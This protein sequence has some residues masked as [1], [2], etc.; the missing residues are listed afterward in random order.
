LSI[1]EDFERLKLLEYSKENICRKVNTDIIIS[2]EEYELYTPYRIDVIENVS[3]DEDNKIS[4]ELGNYKITDAILNEDGSIGLCKIQV[5]DGKIRS[6]RLEHDTRFAQLRLILQEHKIEPLVRSKLYEKKDG[7]YQVVADVVQ[8]QAL[9]TDSEFAELTDAQKAEF[10]GI[11]LSKYQ[12]LSNEQKKSLYGACK[13]HSV[14]DME[15]A[16]NKQSEFLANPYKTVVIDDKNENEVHELNDFNTKYEGV[17][18]IAVDSQAI[19]NKIWC[20]EPVPI[21]CKFRG[22]LLQFHIQV[23]VQQPI[24]GKPLC[25]ISRMG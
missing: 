14:K 7:K 17:G 18:E 2:E 13:A 21:R 19:P 10:L 24:L 25:D 1:S 16:L 4:F 6:V 8:Q 15:D 23:S 20:N 12:A 22:C 11:S 5:G 3:V 9:L